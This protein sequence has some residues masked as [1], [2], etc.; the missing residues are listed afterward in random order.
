MS[1]NTTAPRRRRR[2]GVRG[3]IL[4]VGAAG[5]AAALAVGGMALSGY[6]SAG[7][8]RDDVARLARA[9]TNVQ[10]VETSNADVTGWQTAYAWDARRV[11]GAAAVAED[12]ANRA[13]FLDS[14]ARLRKQL[15]VMP[16][17]VLTDHERAVFEK[18]QEQWKA[19]FAVDD[20]VVAA[21][22]Q[23]TPAAVA[24]GDAL[25]LGDGY[26]VYYEVLQLTAELRQSLTDRVATADRGADD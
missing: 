22:A 17:D 14:A 25:V 18:I 10:E 9:L 13:G 6:G 3:S 15:E 24:A 20:R 23:S 19:Y 5:M 2:L 1:E 11:G 4:A 21:Y 26:N 16:T 12:N 8:A 7:Q